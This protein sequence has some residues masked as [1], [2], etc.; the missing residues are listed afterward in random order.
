MIKLE[1]ISK[2]FEGSFRPIINNVSLELQKGEF[3]III[4]SNGSGKS[5]FLR[6]IAGEHKVDEGSIFVQGTD[7]TRKNRNDYITSVVQDVNKGT[8]PEMTLLENMVLSYKGDKISGLS[9]YKN[10]RSNILHEIQKLGIGLEA[11]LDTKLM[12]LSGGQ[13]QII[14]TVM[15]IISEPKIL[16][17]DEH[18]SALDPKIQRILM[19]Y[20]ISTIKENNITSFMVTHRLDDA[21]KYGDRLV[22]IH[23]GEIVFD[24]KGDKKSSITIDE[25]LSL[26]HKYENLSLIGGKDE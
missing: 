17:L 19:N 1:N 18:T 11:Y 16:L 22:M 12:H 6:L 10:F 20:T 24:I 21:I 15:A 2:S 9:F 23:N 7:V 13:R 5:T 4:G 26:F 14:A 3:C 25:L 8:I